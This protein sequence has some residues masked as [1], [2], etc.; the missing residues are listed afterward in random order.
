MALGD[1][2]VAILTGGGIGA[3]V[4]TIA[5]ALIQARSGKHESRA[6]AA[7]MLA[8]ASGTLS[9]HYVAEIARLVENATVMRGAIGELTDVVDEVLAAKAMTE[10]QKRRL[11]KANQA[12]KSAT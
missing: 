1:N 9:T 8:E 6:N 10:D 11:R 2:L 12:A 7:D 3:G 5:T 4:A